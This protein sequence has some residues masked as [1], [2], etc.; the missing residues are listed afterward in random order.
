MSSTCPTA[1]YHMSHFFFLFCDQ[2]WLTE[3]HE[4]AQQDVVLMLL[5]NKARHYAKYLETT[6]TVD[7]HAKKNICL[8][9]KASN[10]ASLAKRC[11]V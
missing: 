11:L 7:M 5:G 6:N 9:L 3:I 2:A 1:T 4:Y 8:S 10:I